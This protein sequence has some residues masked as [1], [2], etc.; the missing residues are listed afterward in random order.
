MALLG[1]SASLALL[2]AST[3]AGA[4]NQIATSRF[5]SIRHTGRQVRS[6]IIVEAREYHDGVLGMALKNNIIKP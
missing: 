6:F 4:D 5:T 2:G 1:V 3:L